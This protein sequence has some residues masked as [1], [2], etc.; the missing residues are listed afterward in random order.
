MSS[1]RRV[2]QK[3]VERRKEP[4]PR[5]N[6]CEAAEEEETVYEQ[7]LSLLGPKKRKTKSLNKR[8]KDHG[9]RRLPSAD[10]TLPLAD[11]HEP[12]TDQSQPI[13]SDE[14]TECE[15][16][17]TGGICD[18]VEGDG[19]IGDG[20]SG[21]GGDSDG[22][23]SETETKA[24]GDP[25]RLH[26]DHLLTSDEMSLLSS[27]SP[28]L[29]PSHSPTLG[30]VTHI[31]GIPG[32]ELAVSQHPV[33]LSQLGIKPKLCHNWTA[34]SP[35]ASE[36]TDIQRHLFPIIASYKDLLFSHR[37]V[38][39]SEELRRLYVLHILN[40][41]LKTTSRIL[42]NNHKLLQ[43]SKEGRHIEEPRDQGLTRPKVLILLPFRHSA[44]QVVESLT[45]LLLPPGQG[46]VHNQRRFRREYGAEDPAGQRVVPKPSSFTALFS[47]N[48]DDCF[49]VGVAIRGRM[50]RLFADFYSSDII[51]ASPLGLRTIIGADG[52]KKRDYDFL[53]S[54]EILVLDQTDVFLMQNWEHVTHVLNHL[55]LK[56]RE[57]HGVDFSRVRLW[58][59]N[60]WSKSYRQTIVLSSFLTPEINSIFTTYCFNYVG[61]AR[62]D[63]GREEGSVGQVARQLPQMFARLSPSVSPSQLPD[64][65]MKHFSSQVLPS[66]RGDLMKGTVIFIPSYFDFVRVRNLMKKEELSIA[67]LSEYTTTSGV[68]RARTQFYQGVTHFLLYTERAHFFHRL[69]AH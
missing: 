10:E 57:A 49:K 43:A 68:T 39:N 47:G 12:L 46:V 52:D 14:R 6:G 36:L 2:K 4:Q 7:L 27:S 41:V 61:G 15:G 9:S 20:E 50:V 38:E 59:L 31:P 51:L 23:E 63:G 26:F 66:Y 30:L 19:E 16:G 54:V 37:T 67:A 25:F 42:K 60:E 53:S 45:S 1:S 69:R 32:S 3:L 8:R 22:D 28:S 56:P 55:H 17:K 24:N 34:N 35:A 11:K 62:C 58:V 48:T 64:H 29:L 33:S 18:G 13:P 5:G 40:H 21:D 44:L 65:R